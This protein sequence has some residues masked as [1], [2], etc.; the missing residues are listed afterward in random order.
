MLR[1]ARTSAG[2]LCEQEPAVAQQSHGYHGCVQAT[3]PRRHRQ[4]L[5]SNTGRS[6]VM[7]MERTYRRS[8]KASASR[9]TH[10]DGSDAG[11]GGGRG[12]GGGSGG[13][14]GSTCYPLHSSILL[15][16]FGA[17]IASAATSSVDDSSVPDTADPS[18]LASNKQTELASIKRLLR[19]VFKDLLTIK[20]NIEKLKDKNA[21]SSSWS[22]P[23]MGTTYTG[24]VSWG[25]AYVLLNEEADPTVT[26][27]LLNAAL[28]KIGSA[29]SCKES[30]GRC[31]SR[32]DEIH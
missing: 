11:D 8:V 14:G 22:G 6:T 29:V 19:E 23:G 16:G 25:G 3:V 18:E 17:G 27:K 12:R 1:T 21:S 32:G 20:G 4:L 26:T 5:G 31:L 24:N 2:S 28:L 9:H 13:G 30:M 15:G 7:A 10:G